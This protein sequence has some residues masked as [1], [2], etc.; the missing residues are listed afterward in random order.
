MGLLIKKQI[1]NLTKQTE[2][3]TA[4]TYDE[5]LDFLGDYYENLTK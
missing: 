4:Y 1:I 5:Y 3:I 2:N